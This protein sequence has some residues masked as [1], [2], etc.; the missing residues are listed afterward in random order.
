MISYERGV[1]SEPCVTWTPRKLTG[2]DNPAT[3]AELE[4]FQRAF[5]LLEGKWK[6]EILWL[7]SYGPKRFNELRRLLPNITQHM[8]SM[9]LRELEKIGFVV[10]VEYD[11][12]LPRVEYYITEPVVD[13]TN[14]FRA[15]LD[16]ADRYPVFFD[17]DHP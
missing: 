13:L 15:F 7:L 10:R 3:P 9:R 2:S 14:M 17:K 12:S 6:T 16:W 8:L 4:R 11:E 1:A 5:K